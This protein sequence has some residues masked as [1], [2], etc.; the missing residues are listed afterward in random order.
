MPA[1]QAGTVPTSRRS[2]TP[3]WL[4][5]CLDWL[6]PAGANARQSR[7]NL[8][9]FFKHEGHQHIDLV[10]GDFA[11]GDGDALLLDPCALQPPQGPG[12]AG[13]AFLDGILEALL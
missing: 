7:L 3:G 5:T 2:W 11:V 10:A 1:I 8:S 13:N 4:E 9:R 6:R 12:R